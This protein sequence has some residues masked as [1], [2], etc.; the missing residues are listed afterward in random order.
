MAQFFKTLG[1]GLLYTV[2]LPFALLLLAL[3]A[4]YGF[5]V[6]LIQLV[7]NIVVFF[8]GG[9]VGGDLPE[10]VEAKKILIEKQRA[11]LK[12]TPDAPITTNNTTSNNTTN[13]I[14]IVA[15]DKDAD[16]SGILPKITELTAKKE[17]DAIEEKEPIEIEHKEEEKE[18]EEDE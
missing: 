16:L 2:V 5:V 17:P 9:T 4:I 11:E 8:S 13:N 10:D 1:L 14:F 3:Y 12:V 6:F 18:V 7:R 15:G